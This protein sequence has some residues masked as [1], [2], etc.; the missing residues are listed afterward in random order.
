[1]TPSKPDDEED[2]QE[3]SIVH[4]SS[5]FAPKSLVLV[6]RHDYFE[7][8]RVK[9]CMSILLYFDFLPKFLSVSCKLHGEKNILKVF[10]VEIKYILKI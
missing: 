10:L 5:M 6:S 7:A 4:H 9:N 8:F 2:D 1:M 3:R